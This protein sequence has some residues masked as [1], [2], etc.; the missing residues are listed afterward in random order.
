MLKIEAKKY[1]SYLF[2][3][4]LLAITYI[5]IIIKIIQ[6]FILAQP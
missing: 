3:T 2:Y 6:L 4:I 5:I 1:I